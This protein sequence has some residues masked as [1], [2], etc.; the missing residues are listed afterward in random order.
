MFIG[1]LCKISSCPSDLAPNDCRDGVNSG[2][3][4]CVEVSA[5]CTLWCIVDISDACCAPASVVASSGMAGGSVIVPCRDEAAAAIACRRMSSGSSYPTAKLLVVSEQHGGPGYPSISHGLRSCS[6]DTPQSTR[7]RRTGK[8]QDELNGP[9]SKVDSVFTSS[10]GESSSSVSRCSSGSSSTPRDFRPRF[11]PKGNS[12][13]GISES[14]SRVFL[15]LAR[16][17]RFSASVPVGHNRITASAA[18]LAAI[19]VCSGL[20]CNFCF[21]ASSGVAS[22]SSAG[23]CGPC[24]GTGGTMLWADLPRNASNCLSNSRCFSTNSLPAGVR[25]SSPD[26]ETSACRSR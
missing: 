3:P 14:A 21:A 4:W 10:V 15:M 19:S 20:S 25:A 24:I 12:N 9:S 1:S 2:G 6:Q 17:R 16:A 18:A 5:T 8:F 23:A 13:G 11:R 7:L 26:W 22:S